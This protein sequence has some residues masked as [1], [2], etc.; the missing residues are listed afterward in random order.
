MM[1]I[2]AAPLQSPRRKALKTGATAA[3]LKSPM[4]HNFMA[5]GLVL[6][7]AMKSFRAKDWP[8]AVISLR[9][10]LDLVPEVGADGVK[11]VEYHHQTSSCS[12]SCSSQ[13]T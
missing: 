12:K 8:N 3:P 11:K 9:K 10:Y 5:P 6:I 1:N 2:L 13:R 7:R 4:A